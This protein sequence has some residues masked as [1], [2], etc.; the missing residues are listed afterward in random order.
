MKSTNLSDIKKV[1]AIAAG[2]GGVGKSS[3]SVN[4]A[5]AMKKAG[6]RVGLLD[7][8]VYGPS[9]L[10]MLPQGILPAL[11]PERPDQIL[12]G[13]TMGIKM[14]ST[15]HFKGAAEAA[16]VRAPIANS[17]ISQFISQVA[18]GD[19]DYLLIDFPPGTGGIQLT[20]LQLAFIDA[21][22]IV[23]TPQEVALLDV[24]KTVHMFHE[25]GVPILGVVE[26]MS[27]FSNPHSGEK[28]FPF[29]QGGGEKLSQEF[30][31]CLLGKVPLDPNIMQCG[32]LGISIFDHFSQSTG[33]LAMQEIALK[34]LELESPRDSVKKFELIWK[35]EASENRLDFSGQAFGQ[36]S[37][38]VRSL[39]QEDA[40]ILGIE[41][42]D[43]L[44]SN[45]RLS[46]LQMRC[47]CVRCKESSSHP[48][49]SEALDPC[50]QAHRICNQGSYALKIYFTSGCSRGMYSFSALRRMRSCI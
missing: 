25:M 14:I 17:M 38:K 29:G 9:I 48:L 11:Y 32:D 33:A 1:L 5:L 42:M 13:E 44:V 30:D 36:G 21:A 50:V 49:N 6:R 18:W 35:K 10:Q 45:Y 20:L 7:A 2:K 3:L 34:I 4:L 27:Y 16:I 28:Y 37:L 26:N 8:D 19:L 46:Q 15:A 40:Y 39:F 23:T 22:L 47:P 12:P 41:W 24:R 43:G 31:L